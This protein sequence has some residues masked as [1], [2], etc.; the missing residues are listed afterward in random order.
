MAPKVVVVENHRSY[1]ITIYGENPLQASGH[2]GPQRQNM[3]TS[4]RSRMKKIEDIPWVLSISQLIL[5]CK[6]T[7]SLTLKT[8]YFI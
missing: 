1:E 7:I 3:D 2:I 6:Q 8:W 4:G 5:S